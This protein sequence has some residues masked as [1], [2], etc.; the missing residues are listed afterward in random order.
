MVGAFDFIEQCADVVVGSPRQRAAHVY[1][2][3]AKWS[4]DL[5]RFALNDSDARKYSFFSTRS[6]TE[7]IE[8]SGYFRHA[9]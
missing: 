5:H 3:H 1:S 4:R 6:L 9:Q 7:R 2:L 8:N